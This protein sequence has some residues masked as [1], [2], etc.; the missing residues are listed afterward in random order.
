MIIFIFKEAFPPVLP[1]ITNVSYPFP[2]IAHFI[3]Q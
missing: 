3:K 2:A 1:A